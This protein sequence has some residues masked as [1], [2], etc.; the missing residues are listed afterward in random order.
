MVWSFSE[1]RRFLTA[2]P[3]FLASL[4]FPVLA[5][6]AVGDSQAAAST[7]SAAA[8]KTA[9]RFEALR[10]S[11]QE[12]WAF[13][14]A[15]PKGGDLHNHLAGAVYAESLLE[16]AAQDGL[17]V[18]AEAMVMGPPC[19]AAAGIRPVR[20]AH[21]D[22]ELRRK[23]L[24]AWSV[25]DWQHSGGSGHR[26]FFGT[27][28]KFWRATVGHRGAMLAETV[29]R[30]A[31]GGLLY[32]ELMES[33]DDGLS[34]HV[35]DSGEWHG[36][37]AAAL[38]EWRDGLRGAVRAGRDAAR[39][40]ESE[41][42]SLLACGT[43]QAD[44]GCGVTVRWLYQVLR[45]QPP[46]QVFAQIATG[47]LLAAEGEGSN[48]VGINL[49]QPE[50]GHYAMRDFSLHMEMIDFLHA[51]YPGVRIALHAGELAPGLVPP[52]GMTFHIRES[53][54]RGHAERIGHGVAVMHE[55]DPYGLLE[56]LRARDVLVEICL[57]SNDV[58]LGV[59]GED[60][61]LA[62]YRKHGV[63][64]TLATDDAGVSRSEMTTEYAR[65]AREH[66]LGYTVLKRMVR[67]SLRYAF[68]P[69]ASLWE[70]DGTPAPSCRDDIARGGRPFTAC[71]AFLEGSEKARL[72]WELE[73]RI[74]AFERTQGRK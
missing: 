3:L 70:R 44:P 47:F 60:H 40:A 15:M 6:P 18:D 52:E 67:N 48:V 7:E 31:R 73:E 35:A 4:V 64:V 68:L 11:P 30:S 36:N 45:E 19:N 24:D 46:A 54:V 53:V 8:I 42:D 26:Q 34:L 25:R 49:V 9:Q 33:L 62:V 14:Q 51:R 39:R 20:D 41:K 10:T 38:E 22:P 69:G 59:R 63:P 43:N 29:S 2:S 13:L 23:I 27:F 28:G 32:L 61:P 17:C 50:D 71:R 65:A 21:A 56:D 16:W 57:S 5:G 66:G 37:Y 12:Q 72:Q 74:A 1:F 55:A 58:I